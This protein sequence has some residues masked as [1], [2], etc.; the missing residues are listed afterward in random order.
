MFL[1]AVSGSIS[2]LTKAAADELKWESD[3]T[4]TKVADKVTEV[5]SVIQKDFFKDDWESLKGYQPPDWYRDAKFGIFIHWGLYSV[6]G[7]ANEWY[8]R[9]MYQQDDDAFKHHVATYGP[10]TKFGYKDFIPRF[11]AEKFDAHH[12]AEVFKKAGAKYVV[13]VAEHHDG[14]AMYDSDF[15]NWTA[16]QMG[17]RRD[18]IGELAQAVRSEGLVFGL[19]SHRAEH[20]WFMNGGMKFD[21]DV[22][23][24][25]YADFYGPAQPD[26]TSPDD[27]YLSNWLA[28]S[29]EL[30]DKYHPQL[31][32]FDWW[33]GEKP[34]FDP[35]LRKFTAYYYDRAAEWKEGVV[36]N[37]KDKAFVPGTSIQDVE[38]GK[39][40]GINP[41]PW[42]TDTSISWKS[43]AYLKDDSLKDAGYLIR[44]LIDTVSRNG[45]LLLD[46]GPKPDGTIPE[47]QEMILMQIGDWLKVN[48]EAIYGTR[49]WI[50]Y[51]EG[52]TNVDGGKFSES[53]VKYQEGDVRYT[54]K[55]NTIYVLCMVAPTQ[56]LTL[57]QLG[58]RYLPDLNVQKAVI[59]GSHGEV[60]CER[61]GQNMVLAPPIKG[62]PYPVVYRLTLSGFAVGRLE[63]KT[64][65]NRLTVGGS[66]QNYDGQT[67][68]KK[69]L[70]MTG[71]K[72]E[73]SQLVTVGA[74]SSEVFEFSDVFPKAGIYSG[75]VFPA[76][77]EE[78]VVGALDWEVALPSI[79]LTGEWQ[80]RKGDKAAWYDPTLKDAS[81]EKVKVPQ[82]WED[83]GYKC[84]HCYGWYR[85][86]LK[87]PKEWKG[88]SLVLPLGKID[89]ADITYFNGKEIGRMG[90][91]PP[92][93]QTAWNQER[94]YEV[95]AKLI[96]FGTD[97]VI[98][99]RVYNLTGGAGLYDGPLG[100]VEVK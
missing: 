20:W 5:E 47:E 2:I 96:H 6:P 42:Q 38:K 100:P 90:I 87:I 22:Q 93:E 46:I 30:V 58:E 94:R 88:H 84:E 86:H 18:V 54:R 33:I 57:V 29:S 92:K 34:V 52:P 81:W 50:T 59:L 16:K 56:P 98:A 28:R 23:D 35:Y 95:P 37:T 71:G 27:E 12:W 72:E 21:S 7:Y 74:E 55:G 67:I 80:F 17:P 14:F 36:L 66:I 62:D 39:L 51:G 31:M 60:K 15:S 73:G 83:M 99:I 89:D 32:Y 91:F 65:G 19:S 79:D 77:P 8:S 24:P 25:K 3:S 53:D 85:L 78:M 70:F 11:K 75:S 49:P 61:W 1:L 10:Q 41:A 43:W 69:M 48:G 40:P 63:L 13:P 64:E 68:V 82:Q 97:N 45:N 26:N 4:K 9:N 44:S 76:T